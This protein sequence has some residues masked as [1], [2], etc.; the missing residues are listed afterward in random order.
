MR[1]ISNLEIGIG[2]WGGAGEMRDDGCGIEDTIGQ[3][4]TRI[5]IDWKA[6]STG[7]NPRQSADEPGAERGMLYRSLER[8]IPEE[9]LMA[10]V[11][12]DPSHPPGVEG[13][14]E[15]ALNRRLQPFW[16]SQ[17]NSQ[18]NLMARKKEAGPPSL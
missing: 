11:K 2:N 8:Q 7:V 4:S 9:N 14:S 13:A 16:A 17:I 18:E 3:G 5:L 6:K 1:G 15:A 10:T 12:D